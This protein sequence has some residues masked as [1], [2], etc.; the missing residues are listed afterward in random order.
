MSH[1]QT[2]FVFQN[3][4]MILGFGSIGRAILPLLMKS[5]IDYSQIYIISKNLNGSEIAEKY[6]LS[7][8]KF[9]VTKDNYFDLLKNNLKKGDFLLNLSVGI[10]SLALIK[11]CQANQILY[12]DAST[13]PWEGGYTDTSIKPSLRTNYA[14]REEVLR[15]KKDNKTTAV[16]THGANPGLVS[17]FVKQALL[18]LAKDNNLSFTQFSTATEWANLS[19]K[20]GI[21]TIHIAERDTQTTSQTKDH[22]EFVNTWS[23]E[24]L[25]SEASQPAELGWG[26]HERHWP[27]DACQ[28]TFGS[29]CG[30]FLNQSGAR[31]KVL[32]WTPTFG[33]FNGFL[34][35]HAESLSIANFLTLEKNKKLIYRPTVHYAYYPCPD[36][37]LSLHELEGRETI[38]HPKSRYLLK[39]ITEGIDELGVLLME[40]EKG[41]YWYGSQLSIQ[42]ARKLV[43]YNNATSLQVVAGILGGMMW[44]IENPNRGI[45]EP[46][47]LDHEFVLN[48][49]LPYL[50]NVE[51][52]YT[53]WTPLKEKTHL[54][55]ESFDA[56]DPWQFLNMRIA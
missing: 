13:E 36:A 17:H 45:V 28:H 16:I 49:A 30:I 26:T 51:G 35:T 44:A 33:P 43:E 40:N 24:G 34:I 12:L 32:T 54:F 7:L 48:I 2:K 14:L 41:A 21:K 47:D 46:E 31:T 4:I 52:F 50:G 39:E 23:V 15:F 29:H 1:K 56:S 25:I 5:N 37:T 18:N 11:Y 42:E 10:S 9:N 55:T 19:K 53:S 6:G 3:R 38:S 8:I 20:L 27:T 22:D